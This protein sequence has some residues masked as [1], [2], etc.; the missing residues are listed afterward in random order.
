MITDDTIAWGEENVKEEAGKDQ[1]S[2]TGS[3]RKGM[4]N[5]ISIQQ[6]HTS[7][8]VSKVKFMGYIIRR[9]EINADLDYSYLR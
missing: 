8:V 4:S 2:N 6:N 5:R 1:S 3:V 7:L 9:K